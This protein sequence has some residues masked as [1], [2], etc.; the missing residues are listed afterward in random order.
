MLIIH[1]KLLLLTLPIFTVAFK[2]HNHAYE[3]TRT[4]NNF[5]VFHADSLHYP[6]PFDIQMSYGGNDTALFVVPHCFIC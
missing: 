3:V 1:D 6:R 2:E 4:K 5:V